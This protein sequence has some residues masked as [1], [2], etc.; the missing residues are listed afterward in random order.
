MPR[1]RILQGGASRD[2]HSE[3]SAS[4]SYR[5]PSLLTVPLELRQE[6]YSY[7]TYSTSH[8]VNLMCTSRRVAKEVKPFLYKRPPAFDGQYQ[9]FDWLKV[10]DSDYLPYVTELS[11]KLI[12]IDPETIVGALGKR[13]REARAN[14]EPLQPGVEDNPYYEAC[15]HDLKRLQK[16]FSLL[17]AVRRLTIVE[18][19]KGDPQPPPPMANNFSKLLGQCFPDVRTIIC[20]QRDFPVNFIANKPKLRCLRFPAN[21]QSSEEEI[22]SLFKQL[23]DLRLEIARTEQAGVSDPYEWACSTEILPHVPPIHSLSLTEDFEETSSDLLGEIFDDSIEAMKRHVRSIRKL[24]IM[25]DPPTDSQR[26]GLTR[27]NLLRFLEVSQLRHVEVLGTYASIYKHLPGT[28][29]KFVLRLDRWCCDQD[30]S[31]SDVMDDF[32]EHV[33]FRAVNKD[34]KIPK[35]SALKSIE[36]WIHEHNDLLEPE[37][38][39]DDATLIEEKVSA[40][41]KKI[42]VHFRLVILPLDTDDMDG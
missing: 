36:C 19:K 32:M 4:L 34:P 17:P 33:K 7:F 29:E 24:T 37:D 12:D 9:L 14:R 13:L 38:D 35:L 8:L 39:E 3:A 31:F 15:Y 23:P 40:Q 20:T 27:R 5:R 18:A 26:A 2:G 6:I 16:A 1:Q 42:G 41:L 10:A 25:A 30:G 22:A 21:S 11:F 28:V